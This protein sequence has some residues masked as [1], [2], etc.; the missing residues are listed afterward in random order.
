MPIT[1]SIPL[2]LLI[3]R[4]LVTILENLHIKPMKKPSKTAKDNKHLH[5]SLG[6]PKYTP[7][8]HEEEEKKEK[9]KSH[10]CDCKKK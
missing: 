8:K 9:T 6:I 3:Q 7:L 4:I 2:L 10:N 5:N 1:Q